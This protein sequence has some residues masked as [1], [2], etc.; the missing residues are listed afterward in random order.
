MDRLWKPRRY[1]TKLET[2][3]EGRETQR[4]TPG[5]QIGA[6]KADACFPKKEQGIHT[7]GFNYE[8]PP[9]LRHYE[10]LGSNL[11]ELLHRHVSSPLPGLVV[12]GQLP[13]TPTGATFCWNFIVKSVVNQSCVYCSLRMVY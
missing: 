4:T 9:V 3:R 7:H 11:V 13:Q 8:T 1:L 10:I 12:S 2:G 6:G 5:V